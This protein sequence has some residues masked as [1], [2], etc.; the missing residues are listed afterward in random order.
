MKVPGYPDEE[1]EDANSLIDQKL[2][3]VSM[4]CGAT[5]PSGERYNGRFNLSGDIQEAKEADID[6][7]DPE[8]MA[9]WYGVSLIEYQQGQTGI[10]EDLPKLPNK[11]EEPTS[12]GLIEAFLSMKQFASENID[13]LRREAGLDPDTG[14]PVEPTN[15]TEPQPADA[16]APPA[17]RRNGHKASMVTHR[18]R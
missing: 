16:P 9:E 10:R 4:L 5:L 8:A 6:I 14:W 12:D 7:N 13:R 18:V 2:A 1:L 17:P 3:L 15:G 11:D